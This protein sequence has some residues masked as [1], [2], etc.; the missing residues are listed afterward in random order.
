[1]DR[2]RW[3]ILGTGNI[4]RKFATGVAAV[5]EQVVTAVGSRTQAAADRFAGE[6]GIDRR[7]ASYDALAADPTVDAIYIATPH[8]LHMENTLLCLEAGKPVLVEKPFAINLAQGEAMVAA[9]RRHRVFLMEAMWTRYLPIVVEL[10]RLVVEGAIGQV[11]MVQADFGYRAGFNPASRIFDPALGGGGLLDVGIYPISLAYFLLGE[12]AQV[13]SLAEL[14]Q[15]QVDE[16]LGMLFGYAGGALALL[17]TAITTSTPH[18]ATILGTTGWIR[19]H[20]PWWVG[21]ALTLYRTG[22]APQLIERP[23]LGN[24]YSHEAMEVAACV[25]AGRLESPAMPLDESLAIMRTMDLIRAQVGVK[26][27]ME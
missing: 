24:G 14:G 7:H 3:G 2:F 4:A 16:Q 11:R 5:E 25:R 19:V 22:E 13:T 10:K 1:M 8:S 17:S 18:E 15:T 20:S 23:F 26:Y 6:F 27:P 21:K 9:A 12:P